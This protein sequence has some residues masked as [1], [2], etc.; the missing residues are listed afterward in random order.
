LVITVLRNSTRCTPRIVLATGHGTRH[1]ILI[2]LSAMRNARRTCSV[3]SHSMPDHEWFA[4]GLIPD[5]QSWGIAQ[6]TCAAQRKRRCGRVRTCCL[7]SISHNPKH[8]A[9]DRFRTI[10][11]PNQGLLPRP[12]PPCTRASILR[13]WLPP[14]VCLPAHHDPGVPRPQRTDQDVSARLRPPLSTRA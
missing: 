10:P 2:R 9:A 3:S 12:R 5:R 6:A 11:R 8:C 4:T 1:M 13:P 14:A 7:T